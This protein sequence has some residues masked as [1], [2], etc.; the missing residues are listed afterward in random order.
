MEGGVQNE[1]NRRIKVPSMPPPFKGAAAQHGAR[2]NTRVPVAVLGFLKMEVQKLG[3][4]SR[5]TGP[6]CG[7]AEV[8]LGSPLEVLG[9]FAEA[10][11]TLPGRSHTGGSR[12]HKRHS[13]PGSPQYS[14]NFVGSRGRIPARHDVRDDAVVS[15]AIAPYS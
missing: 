15:V 5:V 3:P 4:S 7:R 6:G 11:S 10:T 9:N 12:Q 14:I 1:R 13:L 2:V 8:S